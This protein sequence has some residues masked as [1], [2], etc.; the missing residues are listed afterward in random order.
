MAYFIVRVE[1]HELNS[2][3]KPTWEDYER[4]HAAMQKSN[5]YRVINGD[6]GNWYHMPHATYSATS[7]TS[8]KAQ[9]LENVKAVVQTVWS[10]AGKLVTEGPST[11]DGLIPASAQ[12][13]QRLTS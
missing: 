12:D 11:W 5:Y 8:S 6:N 9:I 3:Q 4:L 10:K 2:K 1:L 7:G 13:V